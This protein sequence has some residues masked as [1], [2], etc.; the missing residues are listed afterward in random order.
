MQKARFGIRIEKRA[1]KKH[2]RFN[3]SQRGEYYRSSRKDYK[4]VR[5]EEEL[6][7]GSGTLWQFPYISQADPYRCSLAPAPLRKFV[8]TSRQPQKVKIK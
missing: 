2:V 6:A 5:V 1:E 8:S 7:E 3:E 4:P